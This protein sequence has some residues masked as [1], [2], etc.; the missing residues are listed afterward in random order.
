MI[1]KKD[2]RFTID[3]NCRMRVFMTKYFKISM[4]CQLS[5]LKLFHE[6]VPYSA[7]ATLRYIF[8]YKN[9][10]RKDEL[11][12]FWLETFHWNNFVIVSWRTSFPIILSYKAIIIDCESNKTLQPTCSFSI[13]QRIEYTDA[14]ACIK[15]FRS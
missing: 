13:S 3:F 7:N 5:I 14:T 2:F 1:L 11:V 15:I 9:I 4:V 6:S 8:V 10:H 12:G